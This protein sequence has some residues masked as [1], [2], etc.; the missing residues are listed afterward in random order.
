MVI[1]GATGA[2]LAVSVAA[3]LVTLPTELVTTTV[4][5]APLSE[6][7]VAGVVYLDEVAPLMAVLFFSAAMV[8]V[9]NILTDLVYRLIDPRIRTGA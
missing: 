2:G 3:L 1:E 8:M 7:V 4:N 6:L 5:S 9:A